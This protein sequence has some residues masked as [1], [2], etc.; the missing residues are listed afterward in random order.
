MICFIEVYEE[1]YFLLDFGRLE[2]VMVENILF[3][4][5]RERVDAEQVKDKVTPQL[6]YNLEM[7]F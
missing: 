4:K 3:K 1:Q 7:K 6:T 5:K 2:I